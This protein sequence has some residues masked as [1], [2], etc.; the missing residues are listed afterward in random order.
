MTA[1]SSG[2][3]VMG[4]TIMFYRLA[5]ACLDHLVSFSDH[6]SLFNTHSHAKTTEMGLPGM[7]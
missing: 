7:W 3:K 5:M 1:S 6:D 4:E 2:W